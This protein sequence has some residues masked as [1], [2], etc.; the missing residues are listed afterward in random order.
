MAPS[1]IQ[2]W[3]RRAPFRTFRIWILET[4]SYEIPH[5]ELVMVK[6]ASLD[7]FDPDENDGKPVPRHT[8][9]CRHITRL[10]RLGD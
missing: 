6:I 1:D 9:A 4:L 5:P 3:L 8:I 2:E 10:E 7:I